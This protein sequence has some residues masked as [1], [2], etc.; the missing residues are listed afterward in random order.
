M[1]DVPCQDGASLP[2]ST[3]L[4]L[5]KACLRFEAAW[6]AGERPSIPAFLGEAAAADRAA[7]LPELIYLEIHYR[8]LAHEDPQPQE[9]L[10]LFPSLEAACG[11]APELRPGSRN[12]W[13]TTKRR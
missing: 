6:K 12:S 11:G 7:L 3:A 9:Y 10:A 13:P 4:R 8:R 1:N 2:L 5:D